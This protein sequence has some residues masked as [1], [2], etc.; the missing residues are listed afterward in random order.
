MVLAW[1]RLGQPPNVQQLQAMNTS[2]VPMMNTIHVVAKLVTQMIFVGH[3]PT[4]EQT[5]AL[6]QALAPLKPSI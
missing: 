1:S 3:P 4:P 6:E 5:E 2:W